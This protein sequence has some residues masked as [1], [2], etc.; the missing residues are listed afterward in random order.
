MYGIE[1]EIIK[2]DN[3]GKSFTTVSS[4]FIGCENI[5]DVKKNLLDSGIKDKNKMNWC[6]LLKSGNEY[7]IGHD[8]FTLVMMAAS[9]PLLYVTLS[10]YES[11]QDLSIHLSQKTAL[12]SISIFE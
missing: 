7:M 4:D 5:K 11:I 3:N 8:L 9:K 12:E 6:Y 10:H 1:L 2:K